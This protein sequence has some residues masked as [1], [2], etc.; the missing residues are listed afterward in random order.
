[1]Y[2]AR[3]KIK[4]LPSAENRPCR[5]RAQSIM[6]AMTTTMIRRKI[7]K[8]KESYPSWCYLAVATTAGRRRTCTARRRDVALALATPTPTSAKT[9]RVVRIGNGPSSEFGKSCDNT[10]VVLSLLTPI[11]I[12]FYDLKTTTPPRCLARTHGSPPLG[13][14]RPSPLVRSLPASPRGP[15]RGRGRSPRWVGGSRP[16]SRRGRATT[17]QATFVVEAD[18]VYR[19]TPPPL[20]LRRR[21]VG[22]RSPACG[23][24]S[25]PSEAAVLPGNSQSKSHLGGFAVVRVHMGRKLFSIPTFW[26]ASP[27]VGGHP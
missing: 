18:L 11:Y 1:M 26:R 25:S 20:L 14:E 6:M 17:H 24:S 2:R 10:N 19:L 9:N 23:P 7:Y 8:H 13:H 3:S 22:R 21:D 12:T 5:R 27:G 16:R 15:L 4:K